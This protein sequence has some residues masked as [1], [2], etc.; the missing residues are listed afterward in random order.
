MITAIAAIIFFVIG[1][2][3]LIPFVV[4]VHK[5][6]RQILALFAL[7]P[8]YSVFYENILTFFKISEEIE[9]IEIY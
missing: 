6:N 5:V 9:K 3:I 4:R 2:S 7:I 1:F 8:T